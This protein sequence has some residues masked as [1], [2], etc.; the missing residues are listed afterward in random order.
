M[1]RRGVPDQGLGQCSPLGQRVPPAPSPG[2][3]RGPGSFVAP[4][5][6]RGTVRGPSRFVPQN[7]PFVPQ[8]VPYVPPTVVQTCAIPTIPDGVRQYVRQRYGSMMPSPNDPARA[9]KRARVRDI[10]ANDPSIRPALTQIANQLRGC[11]PADLNG[12]A[13]MTTLPPRTLKSCDPC[14]AGTVWWKTPSIYIAT[15]TKP[16]ISSAGVCCP[17][18][19]TPNW[20]AMAYEG[21]GT[22]VEATDCGD[23][24]LGDAV[25]EGLIAGAAAALLI[26]LFKV[27]LPNIPVPV[28]A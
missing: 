11:S 5:A 20:W 19:V 15:G 8:N 26:G 24:G 13:N 22:C 6:P 2:P 14:P 9:A 4:S 23:G 12:L 25:I 10:I 3:S 21:E 7:V 1:R 18:G 16:G 27:R 28:P 17:S